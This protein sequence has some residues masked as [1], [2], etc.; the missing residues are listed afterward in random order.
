MMNK[1]DAGAHPGR[2]TLVFNFDLVLHATGKGGA[3]SFVQQAVFMPSQQT[4]I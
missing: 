3:K 4:Q 2:G 1:T